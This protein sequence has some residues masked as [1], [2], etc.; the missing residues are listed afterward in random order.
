[1]GGGGGAGAFLDTFILC[2]NGSFSSLYNLHDVTVSLDKPKYHFSCQ[3]TFDADYLA[4]VDKLK[5][6]DVFANE[7]IIHKNNKYLQQDDTIAITT[8][9][10][11]IIHTTSYEK[12]AVLE[13]DEKSFVVCMTTCSENIVNGYYTFSLKRL[14]KRRVVL[15]YHKVQSFTTFPLRT[16]I[17][18][19]EAQYMLINKT[20]I[21]NTIHKLCG[22]TK[23]TI[24]NVSLLRK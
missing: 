1:M 14:H 10:V 4:V 21:V 12:V 5:Q 19:N 18:L 3:H 11:G 6:L 16:L 22:D 23:F 2:N 17:K 9:I 20:S 13:E 24:N 8:S 7:T 15:I